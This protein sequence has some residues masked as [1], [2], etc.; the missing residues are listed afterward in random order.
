[1]SAADRKRIGYSTLLALAVGFV[2]A[3]MASNVLLRGWRIDLTENRLYTLS[4]GTRALLESIDEPI[5]LYLFSS[6]QETSNLPALRSYE[7]RVR[8]TLEEF[9]AHAPDGRLVLSVLDPVRFSE[10]EDR[11][12]QYGLQAAN[13]GQGGEPVYFGLA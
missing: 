13:V 12:E 2:L 5:N 3:V 11:A 6:D 8:E 1:M 10:E 4:P 9:V 7:T